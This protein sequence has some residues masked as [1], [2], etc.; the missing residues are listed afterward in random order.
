M[1]RRAAALPSSVSIPRTGIFAVSPRFSPSAGRFSLLLS[2]FFAFSFLA[3]VSSERSFMDY[4]QFSYPKTIDITVNAHYRISRFKVVS[5]LMTI[6]PEGK[7]DK[8]AER[9]KKA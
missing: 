9:Q 4:K 6:S 2:S 7:R 8:L 1:E 3:S 5:A